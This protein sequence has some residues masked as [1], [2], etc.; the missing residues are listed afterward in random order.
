M[1]TR[2]RPPTMPPPTPGSGRAGRQPGRVTLLDAMRDPALF[3]PLFAGRSWA[4][5][6]RVAAV[7]FGQIADLSADDRQVIQ[8]CVGRSRLPTTPFSE[9][10][11]LIGRR[12][13]KSA[14][15]ALVAVY[16]ACF[17]NYRPLLAPGERGVLMVIAAD[18]HQ[19]FDHLAAVGPLSRGR[20]RPVVDLYLQ[21]SARAE[22]LAVQI[23]LRRAERRVPSLSE[24]LDGRGQEEAS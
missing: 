5:W 19:P 11:F 9:A 12:G 18:R 24:Y 23:G 4:P 17:R 22:R 15:A 6:R 21:A 20:R 3:G 16:L 1:T 14:F 8:R 2:S 7:L 13:G 10:W